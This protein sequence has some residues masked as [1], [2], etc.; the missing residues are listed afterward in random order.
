MEVVLPALLALMVSCCTSPAVTRSQADQPVSASGYLDE[1]IYDATVHDNYDLKFNDGPLRMSVIRMRLVPLDEIGPDAPPP[2]TQADTALAFRR[3]HPHPADMTHRHRAERAERDVRETSGFFPQS[4]LAIDDAGALKA[5][6][7]KMR[8][9]GREDKWT[10]T[11]ELGNHP[12]P[13]DI[14]I[15]ELP[16]ADIDRTL[17]IVKA[18][19]QIG[20]RRAIGPLLEKWKRA[21]RGTPG[22]RYIPDALAAIGDPSVVPELIAPLEKCRFDYRFHIA[23]ALG[24]LGGA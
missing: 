13:V 1:P 3:S 15:A 14:L 21:P 20:D 4:D 24:M 16:E 19:A 8:A 7:E 9:A 2:L 12:Q 17:F 23:H 18:L 22:T 10:A 11:E 5:A 6:I